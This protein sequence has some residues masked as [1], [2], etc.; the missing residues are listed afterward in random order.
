M[1]APRK[2]EGPSPTAL[3]A[4]LFTLSSLGCALAA[5]Q[6]QL[7]A[8]RA[9]QG[10]GS[11]FVSPAALSIVTSSFTEGDDRNRAV[12]M[13]GAM[14]ALGGSLARYSAGC[15]RRPSAGPPSSR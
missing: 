15:S 9:A 13:W 12:A 2:S 5:T 4:A 6:G 10:V 3:R 7:L 14:G 11:A 8:A 1:A